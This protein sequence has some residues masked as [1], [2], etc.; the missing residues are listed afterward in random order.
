MSLKTDDVRIYIGN[1]SSL[2]QPT[3]VLAWNV[4]GTVITTNQAYLGQRDEEA[5]VHA[6]GGTVNITT[7]YDG[8]DSATL[9]QMAGSDARI[10]LVDDGVM[11]ECYPVT[12]NDQSRTA[13]QVDA[14]TAS[15]SFPMNGVGVYG[16]RAVTANLTNG[17]TSQTVNTTG[18]ASAHV[19]VTR[20]VG[21]VTAV[22]LGK[23]GAGN[24]VSVPNSVGIHEVAIPSGGRAADAVL[25]AT[26]P[27]NAFFDA[28]VLVGTKIASPEG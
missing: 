2:V 5:S 21:N 24:S 22:S 10:A 1:S 28:V 7:M 14:I 17:S 11:F 19:I 26:V 6:Q 15:P 4:T 9:R 27:N 18:F 20:V 25:S 8:T 16:T 12:V 23:S 13:P 3:G